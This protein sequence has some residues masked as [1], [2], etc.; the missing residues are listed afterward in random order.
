[1]DTA[2]PESR[3]PATWLT[4]TAIAIAVV[5]G[6]PFG[7]LT[8]TWGLFGL[9]PAFIGAIFVCALLSALATDHYAPVALGLPQALPVP[10]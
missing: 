7:L 1:M 5:A 8:A 9:I 10:P 3:P 4:P 6:V 2:A